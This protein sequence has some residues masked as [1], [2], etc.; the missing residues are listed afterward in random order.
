MKKF[1][2]I[3][4]V[5]ASTL[6]STSAFSAT[7]MVRQERLSDPNIPQNTNATL[8]KIGG[9]S[10]NTFFGAQVSHKGKTLSTYQ[11]GSGEVQLGYRYDVNDTIRLTPQLQ[12][13]SSTSGLM[14]KPQLGFRYQLG[15]GLSTEL[16]YK[17]EFFV[18]NNDSD[19]AE[20]SQYQ[21]N[22]NYKV[23]ALTLGLQYDY[24]KSLDNVKQYNHHDFK[25]LLELKAYYRVAK[26]WTPFVTF[27][28]VPVSNV[29]EDYQLRTR[30]GFLYS[31]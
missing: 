18:R 3:T 15:G 12:V 28:G 6:L 13:T 21:F 31:F 19:T 4:L 11:L 29:S 27:S 25:Q 9:S 1:N 22:L 23:K 17:H 8:I 24:F 14:W 20:K 26:G 5:V 7:L 2:L 30:V 10:G 16:K